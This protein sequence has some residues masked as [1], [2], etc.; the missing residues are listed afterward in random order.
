MRSVASAGMFKAASLRLQ[1]GRSGG[2][3]SGLI[4]MGLL[5]VRLHH[6][7]CPCLWKQL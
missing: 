5:A 1:W 6:P 2:R 7:E 3:C 4:P